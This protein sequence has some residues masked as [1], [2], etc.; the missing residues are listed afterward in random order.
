LRRLITLAFTVETS[1]FTSNSATKYGGGI[2]INSHTVVANVKTSQFN[3]NT[4][5]EGGAAKYFG[6]EPTFEAS[7]TFEL[8]SASLFGDDVAGPIL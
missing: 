3:S 5:E 1:I 4:A 8:N 7:N 2:F 6:V